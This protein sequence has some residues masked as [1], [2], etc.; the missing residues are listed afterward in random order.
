MD[1]STNM[2]ADMLQTRVA[3]IYGTNRVIMDRGFASGGPKVKD[4]HIPC[5]QRRVID[6]DV[7]AINRAIYLSVADVV[8]GDRYLA[9]YLRRRD[10]ISH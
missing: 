2:E 1:V 10:L 4:L 8:A 5:P 7:A 3:L 9:E 6:P